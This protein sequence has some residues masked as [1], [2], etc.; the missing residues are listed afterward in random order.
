MICFKPFLFN[1]NQEYSSLTLRNIAFIKKSFTIFYNIFFHLILVDQFSFIVCMTTNQFNWNSFVFSFSWWKKLIFSSASETKWRYSIYQK[2]TFLM[3]E[4]NKL[5]DWLLVIILILKFISLLTNLKVFIDWIY[6]FIDLK[7]I[8]IIYVLTK[9]SRVY[10]FSWRSLIF[11][12]LS[13]HH[14]KT[15]WFLYSKTRIYYD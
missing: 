3:I 8:V 11:V 15:H 5:F 12:V 1:I 9:L 4:N 10:R 13:N 7:L 2:L 14:S 6:D